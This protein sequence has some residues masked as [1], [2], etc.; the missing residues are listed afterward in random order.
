MTKP[1]TCFVC[2]HKTLEE[3]CDWEI[4]PV[5]GWEDDTLLIDGVDQRSP[6]NK[7]KTISEAQANFMVF[8]AS[9]EQRIDRCRPPKPDEPLDPTWKPLDEAIQLAQSKE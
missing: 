4:C 3:R 9:T 5:C 2:G 1:I 8:G 7:G 6:A